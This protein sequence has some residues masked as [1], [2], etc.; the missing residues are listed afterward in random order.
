MKGKQF[1]W[2]S[3]SV[4]VFAVLVFVVWTVPQSVQAQEAGSA[5]DVVKSRILRF[6]FH[7][8][9]TY[10]LGWGKFPSK[11]LDFPGGKVSLND[12]ADSNVHVRLDLDYRLADRV[13]LVAF[14]GFS[15]FTD[16][17]QVGVHYYTFNLSANLKWFLPATPARWFIQFG[18]GLYIPKNGLP[19]PYPTSNTVG[20]NIGIG[21]QIPLPYPFD[22]EWGIDLHTINLAAANK[23]KY[24]FLTFQLG[25]HFK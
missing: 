7:V 6:S 23:P 22:V 3:R 10:P 4:L 2:L 9:A 1:T 15:Q 5:T 20:A 16:D 8:G 24:W 11:P 14:A 19:L 25:V 12:L 21:A 13:N 17:Y 18:P